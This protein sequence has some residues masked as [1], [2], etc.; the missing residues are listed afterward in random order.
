[1]AEVYITA[2][3]LLKALQEISPKFS[4]Q[5][6][7]ELEE[8]IDSDPNDEWELKEG[9]DYRIAIQA[10]GKREYTASGA[11]TIARCLEARQKP[12]FW[13][14]IKELVLHT[15]RKVRR[16]FINKK[17]LDN[18]SS[19][20][21]RRSHFWISRA[22]LV[23]ILGTNSQT[24]T[25]MLDKAKQMQSPLIQGQDYEDFADGSGIYFSLGG[26]YKISQVFGKN[27]TQKNRRE[28]CEEVGNTIQ[29]QV[30]DIVDT[31]K[32]RDNEIERAMRYVREK[33]DKKTCQVT[34]TKQDRINGLKLAVHHLYSRNAYPAIASNHANLIT[35]SCD[36]HDQFHQ[37]YMGGTNKPCTIDDF[38]DF[39]QRYYPDNTSLVN[40]LT[41]WRVSLN[42]P[43]PIDLSKPPHVLY[44]PAS[45]LIG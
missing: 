27:L 7:I 28:W 15:K 43:Q 45:R 16:A 31:I 6:L 1:M 34:K 24:L 30:N 42:N 12:G 14:R 4:S 18:C 5:D 32:N 44:L 22:D 21:K 8:F 26:I 17:I 20:V 10:T 25:R 38:I 39:V 37:D 9:K 40:Q 11:Y 29:P 35:I 41:S 2:Q 3:E 13:A 19:L 36:V 33:R 23:S